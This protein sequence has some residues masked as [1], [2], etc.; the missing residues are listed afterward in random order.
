M[1]VSLGDVCKKGH[2][3]DGDNVQHY[4]NRGM[5]RVRCATCNQPPKQVSK[6]PGDKCKNNHIIEGDNLGERTTKAGTTQYF[7]KACKREQV[8]KYATSSKGRTISTGR[9]YN[10][11]LKKQRYAQKKAS[12][13][14]DKMIEEG[15]EDSALSYLK[16]AKRA[17]KAAESLYSAMERTEP[18]CADNPGP[19]VDYDED[20]PPTKNQAY[21]M[22]A[23]CPVLVECARFANVYRPEIGVWGGEV[24]QA[25]KV[26]YK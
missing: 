7:C 9:T 23:F 13:R 11:S 2:L 8:K 24:Y 18:N 3:I 19:Y 5:N 20:N 21:L 6:K 1:P 22:C 25:G 26:L 17:E 15:K 10:Q 12:E 4:K 16:M 14:A